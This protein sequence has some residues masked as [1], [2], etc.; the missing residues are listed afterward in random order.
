[1][2]DFIK[3][4]YYIGYFTI[5]IFYCTFRYIITFLLDSSVGLFLLWLMIRW[6]EWFAVNNNYQYLVPGEYGKPRPKTK[7]WVIQCLAYIAIVVIDKLV[8][9]LLLQFGFWSDV[10]ALLLWPTERFLNKQIEL[11]IVLLVIP[12]F[13]NVLMF[14]VT[15][16]FL[17][18]HRVRQLK[19]KP[20]SAQSDPI[21]GFATTA[22]SQ[23]APTD[24][25]IFDEDA[26]L[27]DISFEPDYS[28]NQ[29]IL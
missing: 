18:G 29:N 16:N 15:D 22:G 1:M 25:Q 12:F 17:I 2:T 27:I 13:V 8:I 4:L 7:Y 24:G 3:L 26:E 10:R 11:V 28:D 21:V 9:T 23:T 20:S 6:T 5:S 14:W 19:H